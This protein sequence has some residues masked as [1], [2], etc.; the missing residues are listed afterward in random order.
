MA[1]NTQNTNPPSGAFTANAP[2]TPSKAPRSKT[3]KTAVPQADPTR[4]DAPSEILFKEE[5]NPYRV[6]DPPFLWID[7]PQEKERLRAPV[8]VIRLGV[9]GAQQVELSI[10]SG[11]WEN[12]RL[13][14]GYWWFDWSGIQPGKHTLTARMRTADGR[15]FRTPSRTCDYRP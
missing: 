10:D 3:R 12:C 8:Y 7:Y 13:T 14:S 15:R 2:V 5:P 6:S 4:T 11:P 1:N 9:G